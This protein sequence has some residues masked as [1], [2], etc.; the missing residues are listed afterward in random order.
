MTTEAPTGTKEIWVQAAGQEGPARGPYTI[1]PGTTARDILAAADL[2]GWQLRGAN[3]AF[4]A[5]SV[6]FDEVG[7]QQKLQ[8]VNISGLAAGRA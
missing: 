8:A 1:E 6:V 4:D 3:G 5:D 7:S 2:R